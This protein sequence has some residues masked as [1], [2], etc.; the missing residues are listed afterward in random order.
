MQHRILCSPS[1]SILEVALQ[2]GETI[3][4]EAGAMAWMSANMQTKTNTRGGM[5]G[6]LKRKMLSGESFFQ[7]TY[8]P[9]DGPGLVALTP[10]SPGDIVSYDMEQGE[11]FLEKG[12]YLASE[13]GV[14]C[15]S[16]FEGLKGLFNE[17]MFVLRCTGTGTMFFN[18]YG[19]VE[20]VAVNGEYIVDNGYAVA[21][22]PSLSWKITKGKKIR[23][24]LFS[25]Q[26]L[27]RFSGVGRLWVQSRSPRTMANFV[28]P[29]RPTKN[30]N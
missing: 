19:D 25:D 26:L 9:E 3:V 7:N 16:K 6:G 5:L 14:K 12:A 8:T 10:G 21:W 11:L 28:Y 20:E 27:C 29:Y 13:E 1:Y 24:F 2:T 17:G 15:D 4:A 22:E 23:S 30:N 18:A